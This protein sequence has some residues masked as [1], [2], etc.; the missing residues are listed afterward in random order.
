MHTLRKIITKLKH[1]TN[2]PISP[3]NPSIKFGSI[4]PS[5]NDQMDSPMNTLALGQMVI[6][7]ENNFSF[8]N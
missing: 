6:S 5:K 8:Q 1:G 4:T 3:K 7:H 2:L